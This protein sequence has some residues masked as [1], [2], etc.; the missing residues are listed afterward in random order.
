MGEKHPKE[1]FPRAC[2]FA[3]LDQ[4]AVTALCLQI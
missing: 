4:R 3:L 1:I 2:F